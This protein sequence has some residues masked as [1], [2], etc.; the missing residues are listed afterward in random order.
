MFTFSYSYKPFEG[1]GRPREI[2]LMATKAMSNEAIT[3]MIIYI[4]SLL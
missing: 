3:I 4:I 1:V 2:A